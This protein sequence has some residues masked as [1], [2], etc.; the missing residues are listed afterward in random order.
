[1][2]AALLRLLS[3]CNVQRG[4]SHDQQCYN[5]KEMHLSFLKT[6]MKSG[7]RH[8]YTTLLCIFFHLNCWDTMGT[9]ISPGTRALVAT[10]GPPGRQGRLG[11]AP[12]QDI[13]HV[14]G[15]GDGLRPGQDVSLQARVRPGKGNRGQTQ[16]QDGQAGHEG[17]D[18][19]RLGWDISPAWQGSC[20]GWVGLG[21]AG[22]QH[23]AAASLGQGRT[24][25]RGLKWGPGLWVGWGKPQGG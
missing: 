13:R 15:D 6:K 21:R 11:A 10:G 18:R 16:P 19:P 24:A 8:S 5:I 25:L 14:H 4:T 9:S 3:G 12:A 17:R 22:D 7:T 20:P 2:A 23:F 1:M